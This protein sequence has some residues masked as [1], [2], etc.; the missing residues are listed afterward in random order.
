M[1]GLEYR[2]STPWKGLRQLS[3]TSVC[4][5]R[6]RGAT[7]SP[8]SDHVVL[9]PGVKSLKRE[10]DSFSLLQRVR[11]PR[12]LA[13]TFPIRLDAHS[14][15]S[16]K[17]SVLKI[18]VFW[19]VTPCR[20]SGRCQHIGGASPGFGQKGLCREDGDT[21]FLENVGS[22]LP[23]TRRHIFEDNIPYC[24]QRGRVS[25]TTLPLLTSCC[26]FLSQTGKAWLPHYLSYFQRCLERNV[27]HA[28]C[29]SRKA[30][31]SPCELRLLH[32]IKISFIPGT[33]RL[34]S[35]ISSIFSF[36]SVFVSMVTVVVVLPKL[37]KNVGAK[38]A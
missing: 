17:V 38:V 22:Y 20:M 14:Q 34:L 2:S 19:V 23:H 8:S 1:F 28:R 27:G 9:I 24:L 3:L 15:H 7:N 35:A 26:F 25:L 37:N 29:S 31:R 30:C 33:S 6:I 16:G 13:H 4:L 12:A 21:R 32:V 11:M 5:I 18:S 10:A 36:I